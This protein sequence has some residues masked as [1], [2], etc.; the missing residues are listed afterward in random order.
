MDIK[1]EYIDKR[2]KYCENE[3]TK[4]ILL[5]EVFNQ[6]YD[7]RIFLI[8]AYKNHFYIKEA[9]DEYFDMKLTK[10]MCIE[11]SKAFGELASLIETTTE[12]DGQ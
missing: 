6:L 1:T 3:K 4:E 12:E 8:E 10:E 5:S 7:E 9:C 11:L 2:V